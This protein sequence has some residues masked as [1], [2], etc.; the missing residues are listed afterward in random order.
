MKWLHRFYNFWT[1]THDEEFIEQ[2]QLWQEQD[3]KPQVEWKTKF[4]IDP[5]HHQGITSR[6]SPWP[7]DV[8]PP[9][10]E[11]ESNWGFALD[12]FESC[13]Q[14]GIPAMLTINPKHSYWHQWKARETK[15]Q[16]RDRVRDANTE[17]TKYQKVF[18]SIHSNAD[19][20]RIGQWGNVSGTETFCFPG[21]V[22]SRKI[23][24]VFNQKTVDAM[25]TR[26]R[27]RGKG[28]KEAEFYVLKKTICPAILIET[29]FH[30]SREGYERLTNWEI[31][32]KVVEGWIEAMKE[33]NEMW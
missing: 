8:L 18:I 9:L 22:V 24:S 2:C 13:D 26:D 30:N 17:Q 7:G 14:L 20:T 6:R 11:W 3:D 29:D 21:S 19:T 4:Y 15:D 31:R 33:V 28:Y 27:T 25:G 10:Y 32:E 12:L 23:A 1:K 16:F 5:G